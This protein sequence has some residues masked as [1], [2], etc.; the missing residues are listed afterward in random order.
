M[1]PSF[2]EEEAEWVGPYCVYV[3]HEQPSVIGQSF[4]PLRWS[5]QLAVEIPFRITPQ[6][7]GE[8]RSSLT[9]ALEPLLLPWMHPLKLQ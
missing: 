1:Y 8:A 5:C 4:S 7:P 2:T 9:R 3:K 6:T